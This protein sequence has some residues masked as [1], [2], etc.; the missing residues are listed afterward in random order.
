MGRICICV[1]YLYMCETL[2][3]FH[4]IHTNPIGLEYQL[5]TALCSHTHATLPKCLY[6]LSISTRLP[7]GNMYSKFCL[8]THRQLCAHGVYTQSCISQDHLRIF[9]KEMYSKCIQTL[10]TCSHT[11]N[12][13]KH[14]RYFLLVLYDQLTIH[15]SVHVRNLPSAHTPTHTDCS[16]L[17]HFPLSGSLVIQLSVASVYRFVA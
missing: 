1:G 5:H 15:T 7:F 11:L 10:Q 12:S 6:S 8:S 3:T 4:T 2:C 13:L 16:Y 14:E 9:E 17:I